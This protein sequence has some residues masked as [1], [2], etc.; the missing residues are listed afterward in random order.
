MASVCCI[1]LTKAGEVKCHNNKC[2][3]MLCVACHSDYG[4][5]CPVCTVPRN[6]MAACLENEDTQTMQKAWN[7]YGFQIS[8]TATKAHVHLYRRLTVC[9]SALQLLTQEENKLEHAFA[10]VVVLLQNE[11][12]LINYIKFQGK[13]TDQFV[14][15][16]TSVTL[17]NVLLTYKNETI[18]GIFA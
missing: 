15:R 3:E 2:E 16:R 13:L 10:T 1:C 11:V 6:G 5:Q 7:H 14:S 12:S 4:N 8:V 17:F 18:Y 9:G